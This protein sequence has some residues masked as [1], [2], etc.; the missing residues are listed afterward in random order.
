[1]VRIVFLAGHISVSAKPGAFGVNN[2]AI[3]NAEKRDDVKHS[4]VGMMPRI[5]MHRTN[6]NK[7]GSVLLLYSDGQSQNARSA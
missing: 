2:F 5:Y 4:F 6:S 7:F 1:M 3:A